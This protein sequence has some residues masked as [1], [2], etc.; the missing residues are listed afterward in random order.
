MAGPS[1]VMR[2][3]RFLDGEDLVVDAGME[4]WLDTVQG[5][6]AAGKCMERVHVVVEPLSDYMRYELTWWYP[7][8]V[9][10]GEDIRIIPAQGA[11][12]GRAAEARLLAVR[13][14]PR[15]HPPL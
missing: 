4:E 9:A 2:L 3:R 1:G 11:V 8:N 10:A 5:A 14:Q 15:G 6:R 7:A 13:L 12:A